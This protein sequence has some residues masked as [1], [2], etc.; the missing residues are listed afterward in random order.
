VPGERIKGTRTSE[1]DRLRD[2]A[3]DFEIFRDLFHTG[4]IRISAEPEYHG[5]DEVPSVESRARTKISH[6]RRTLDAWK[7]EGAALD[8]LL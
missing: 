1:P 5:E 7:L 6:I 8:Q 3:D 4:K 2:L